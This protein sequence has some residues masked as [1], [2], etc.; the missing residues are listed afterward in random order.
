MITMRFLYPLLIK[1][2]YKII[3]S[4]IHWAALRLSEQEY[5]QFLLDC[6]EWRNYELAQQQLGNIEF[7]PNLVET[8]TL[9]DG[10]SVTVEIGFHYKVIPN[11]VYHPKFEYWQQRIEQDSDIIYY[12]R[13]I[14]S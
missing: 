3:T 12:P 9:A 5:Q 10:T 11:F 2:G 8:F 7:L 4:W 1:D 6:E 14:V 13:E